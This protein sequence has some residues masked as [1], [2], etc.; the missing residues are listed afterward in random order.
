MHQENKMSH[1][2][3]LFTDSGG[4]TQ[5]IKDGTDFGF[6]DLKDLQK[7]EAAILEHH[8]LNVGAITHERDL[9]FSELDSAGILI[10]PTVKII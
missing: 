2:T 8:K 6:I 9:L 5:L 1:L 4:T 3:K 7:F 10:R